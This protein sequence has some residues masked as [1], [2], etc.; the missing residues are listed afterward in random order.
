MGNWKLFRGVGR[1]G[2]Q[3]LD[4]PLILGAFEIH[5]KNDVLHPLVSDA[6]AEHLLGAADSRAAGD[7]R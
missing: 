3:V 1:W 7:V 5:Q 6:L 4:L 2:T